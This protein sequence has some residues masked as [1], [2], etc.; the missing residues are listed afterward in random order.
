M[1][2]PPARSSVQGRPPYSCTRLRTFH[3]APSTSA[4]SPSP[5]ARISAARP[6]SAG[7]LSAHHTAPSCSST[8]DG[9]PPAAATSAGPIGD[10]HV[11][12]GATF[13]MYAAL[14]PLRVLRTSDNYHQGAR[15]NR[16]V[17]ISNLYGGS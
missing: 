17:R 9:P 12:Y 1:A 2:V 14:P 3:G 4:G 10:G 11:P 13:T 15:P 8:Q 16:P 7:R 6:P 5:A